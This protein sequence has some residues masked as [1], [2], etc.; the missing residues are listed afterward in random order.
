MLVFRGALHSNAITQCGDR[1]GVTG[2]TLTYQGQV[3]LAVADV[4]GVRSILTEATNQVKS[5]T[6][7][8]I[9]LFVHLTGR[10][11]LAS[12]SRDRGHYWSL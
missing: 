10:M 12:L 3:A 6:R 5:P 11:H 4:V 7:K 8:C 2:V 1:V 9:L